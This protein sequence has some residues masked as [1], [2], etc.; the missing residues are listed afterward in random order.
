MLATKI[1]N[2][3]YDIYQSNS[4]TYMAD[5]FFILTLYFIVGMVEL[6]LYPVWRPIYWMI[7][8]K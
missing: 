1:A 2:M 8:K 6:I 7:T 5:A 3:H 4:K